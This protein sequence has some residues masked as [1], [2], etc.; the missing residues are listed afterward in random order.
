MEK[1]SLT[2]SYILGRSVGNWR[3]QAGVFNHRKWRPG[4]L[5]RWTAAVLA[6]VG[7]KIKEFHVVAGDGTDAHSSLRWQEERKGHADGAWLQ[8]HKV[9]AYIGA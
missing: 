5:T 1:E 3:S 7:F 9:T 4:S 6:T 2:S 8:K